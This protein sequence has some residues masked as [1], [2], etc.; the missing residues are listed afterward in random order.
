MTDNQMRPTAWEPSRD[1]TSQ[2]TSPYPTRP[3]QLWPVSSGRSAPGGDET[4]PNLPETGAARRASI[5]QGPQAAGQQARVPSRPLASPAGAGSAPARPASRPAGVSRTP[6]GQPRKPGKHRWKR[7][8]LLTALAILVLG[9][10]LTIGGYFGIYSPARQLANDGA[11]HLQHAQNL[12]K[13]L[14][15]HPLAEKTITAARDEFSA[16][17]S[18]FDGVNTRLSLIGPYL[19]LIGLVS[20]RGDEIQSYVHLAHMALD[21]SKA[22]NT[23]LTAG[24]K[25]IDDEKDAFHS[26]G[27]ATPAISGQSSTQPTG[28]TSAQN[29][30]G[31]KLS[32][33][34]DLQQTASDVIGL[35]EDAWNEVQSVSLSALPSDPSIQ[36][37][38]TLF[39]SDYPSLRQILADLQG[40]IASAPTLFGIGHSTT[41]LAELMDTGERRPTGGFITAYGTLGVQNG[42][43]GSLALQDTYLLDTPYAASHT[44]PIPANDAWFTLSKNWGLRDSNLEPDFPTAA[45]AAEQLYTAE[46]G[47][48]VDGVIAFTSTFFE[49]VLAITGPVQIPELNETIDD[50]NLLDRLHFYQYQ[51]STG[52]EVSPG[53]LAAHN[54]QFPALLSKYLVEKLRQLSPAA[55][56]AVLQEAVLGMGT[57]DIQLY[58]NDARAEQ[59]LIQGHRAGAV[60][61]PNG[62][63]LYVVDTNISANT[64][65]DNLSQL[66]Q[67]NINLDAQGGATHHLTLAYHW[68]GTEPVSGNSYTDYVRIYVPPTS[69]LQGDSGFPTLNTATAY[70]RTVWSSTITLVPGQLL[71][72][73]VT[74]YVPNAVQQQQGQSH[75]SFLLQRQASYP[76]SALALTM[77]LPQNANL[78]QHSTNLTYPD[79]N[80]QFPK[81]K[82]D[83]D[84][85]FTVD[86]N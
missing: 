62:D 11:Q 31:L 49:H 26:S 52:D 43:L 38:V 35:V 84:L 53:Q 79:N 69:Q 63:S 23:A 67:D 10:I 47:G 4:Q 16:A 25:L 29:A 54:N 58:V 6:P 34:N 80:L 41:Y 74:Y 17:E 22:G 12:L 36:A 50:S 71:L 33:I 75:Y 40:T 64:A 73:T 70:Q 59:T 85:T 83:H 42:Q 37:A 78:I 15:L 8:A 3:Q 72:T 32:D 60:E 39:R 7:I 44:T 27:P 2:P 45:K 81:Q 14:A 9:G 30:S 21:L 24:L 18:D 48:P 5:P 1:D 13:Q 46:G 65:N 57:K 19:G 20:G 76:L 68:V 51:R 56:L 82:Q 28:D 86:Y 77:S 55:T 61:A 66:I